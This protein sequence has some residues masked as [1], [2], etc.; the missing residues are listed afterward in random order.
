MKNTIMK[1]FLV[2]LAERTNGRTNQAIPDYYPLFK[3]QLA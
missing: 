2:F 3:I 1:N